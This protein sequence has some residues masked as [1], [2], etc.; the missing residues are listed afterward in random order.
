M[1]R[2]IALALLVICLVS[3][4]PRPAPVPRLAGTPLA[5][6]PAWDSLPDGAWFSVRA[7]PAGS[8][9]AQAILV[10][11]DGRVIY[12]DPSTGA[13]S[14]FQL[15]EQ[16]ITF[17]KRL[18]DQARFMT[19]NQDYA[20][21]T[22]DPSEDDSLHYTILYRQGSDVKKVTAVKSGAPTSLQV[23]LNESLDLIEQVKQS[24]S[25]S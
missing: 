2:M 1:V 13:L 19:L 11:Q 15:D 9:Q 18:F 7:T 24:S 25:S 20:A 6:E 17:W 16:N 22:P 3:C 12:S 4:S 5:V 21:G 10:Y 8:A 14:Q 23:I